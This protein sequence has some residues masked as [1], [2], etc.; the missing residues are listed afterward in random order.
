MSKYKRNMRVRCKSKYGDYGEGIIL[1]VEEGELNKSVTQYLVRLDEN[2]FLNYFFENELK[3]IC[4]AEH[5]ILK[6]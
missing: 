4:N 5:F 2:G 3:K 1:C 6:S